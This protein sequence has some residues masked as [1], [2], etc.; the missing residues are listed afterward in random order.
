MGET[1]KDLYF[2]FFCFSIFMVSFFY[3]NHHVNA[4]RVYGYEEEEI[5]PFNLRELSGAL[6]FR[7]EYEEDEEEGFGKTFETRETRFEERLSLR[8]RGSIYHSNF[9]E[10][11]LNT[12]F[13]LRQ[14]F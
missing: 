6:D 5:R 11:D 7:L 1:I 10:F 13:G 9:L 8:A 12:S 2:K 4:Q 3:P 14:Q